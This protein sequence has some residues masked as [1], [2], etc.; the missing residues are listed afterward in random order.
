MGDPQNER[1]IWRAYSKSASY[2]YV[3]ST[4]EAGI[5]DL[6][7]HYIIQMIRVSIHVRVYD[8]LF[9]PFVAMV[10]ILHDGTAIGF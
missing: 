1:T 10:K 6:P 5:S 8:R 7:G 2:L 4:F 9:L 3:L